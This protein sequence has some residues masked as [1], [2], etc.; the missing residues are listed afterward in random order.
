MTE[1]V[2]K[3]QKQETVTWQSFSHGLAAVILDVFPYAIAIGVGQITKVDET[4]LTRKQR[5][6][7]Y[8][9]KA[10]RRE[11]PKRTTRTIVAVSIID[12][13]VPRSKWE[14]VTAWGDPQAIQQSAARRMAQVAI[15]RYC[16]RFGVG[17]E[18]YFT[19][20]TWFQ[21]RSVEN[22]KESERC[23]G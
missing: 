13:A 6:L 4:P 7:N 1:L 16:K 21:N 10:N 11:S 2:K 23:Y 18:Y 9:R 17:Y 15:D 20:V 19:P 3:E 8:F 5:V 22:T 14:P 12:E